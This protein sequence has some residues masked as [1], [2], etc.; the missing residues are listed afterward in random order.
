[1]LVL[2]G[3]VE[4]AV[5]ATSMSSHHENDIFR[6]KGGWG[7]RKDRPRG[8]AAAVLSKEGERDRGKT[9]YCNWQQRTR[10]EERG[11]RQRIRLQ[12]SDMD[13]RRARGPLR[14]RER[15]RCGNASCRREEKKGKE[16]QKRA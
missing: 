9:C 1:M 13:G 16:V 11:E 7:G 8:A 10:K 15:M 12:N 14:A 3:F 6:N 5:T 2:L 4:W